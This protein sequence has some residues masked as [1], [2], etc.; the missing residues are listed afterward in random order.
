MKY[1]ED[2]SDDENDEK[3]DNSDDK[4]G[5]DY[6]VIDEDNRDVIRAIGQQERDN[7]IEF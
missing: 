2:D 5:K 7:L 6:N 4:D 1:D 3:S